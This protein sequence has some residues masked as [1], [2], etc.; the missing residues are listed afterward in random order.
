MIKQSLVLILRVY[1][2][3]VHNICFVTSSLKHIGVQ[4]APQLA[5]LLLL[6]FQKY[7]LSSLGYR[8]VRGGLQIIQ[9]FVNQG[10]HIELSA[11]KF[12]VGIF[13]FQVVFKSCLCVY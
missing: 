10:W 6:D 2:F 4:L 8:N 7:A 11:A 9:F 13:Q 12:K 1:F 5:G 3:R